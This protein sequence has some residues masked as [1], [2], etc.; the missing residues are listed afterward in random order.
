MYIA[1]AIQPV[2]FYKA[3]LAMLRIVLDVL[4]NLAAAAAAADI[5]AAGAAA[6]IWKAAAAVLHI[7]DLRLLPMVSPLLKIQVQTVTMVLTLLIILHLMHLLPASV[8]ADMSQ[9]AVMD[10]LPLSI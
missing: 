8:L 5:T 6:T 1:A 10:L 9:M 7:L 3:V 4:M 2:H